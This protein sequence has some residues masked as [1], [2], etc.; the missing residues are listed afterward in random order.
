MLF[1]YSLHALPYSL[2]LFPY[3]LPL[4]RPY[5][6]F[7]TETAMPNPEFGLYSIY[8]YISHI[9][10][11]TSI[12]DCDFG[13]TGAAASEIESREVFFINIYQQYLMLLPSCAWLGLVPR[14]LTISLAPGFFLCLRIQSR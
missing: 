8:I 4:K 14:I 11:K 1:S 7:N 2:L 10:P 12:C 9:H 6:L 13:V 5:S 3:S